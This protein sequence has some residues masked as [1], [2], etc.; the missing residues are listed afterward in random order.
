MRYDLLRRA[1]RCRRGAGARRRPRAPARG[2]ARRFTRFRADSELSRLNADPRAAVR[3][4]ATTAACSRRSRGGEPATG[5]L[6]DGTLPGEI[7]AAGYRGDLAPLL[8]LALASGSPR[9]GD[10]PAAPARRRR[11]RARRRRRRLVLRPPGLAFDSGGL[12]KG[13]FADLLAERSTATSPS[14]AAATCASAARAAPA[15]GRRSVRR[16]AAARARGRRRRRRH[17]RHR[18]PR[19]ARRAR[20]ARP[21]PAR[22]GHRAAGV[23]RR[24][25]GDRPRA[26]RLGERR[27]KAAVLARTR[28][29]AH[30]G[31]RARDGEKKSSRR[32]SIRAG[33]D[34]PARERAQRGAA[35]VATRAR[36][37]ASP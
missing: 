20:P 14:T 34:P 15:R 8:P 9:R 22:P 19:L 3:V 26:H 29:G 2:L 35:S 28:R 12:A 24:R 16:P 25:P 33:G 37:P 23:H 5:G 32:R 10:P 11:A 6:V 17:E 36:R 4:S 7:E 31:G 21:P 1:L 27:A 18:P 13:L 30:G